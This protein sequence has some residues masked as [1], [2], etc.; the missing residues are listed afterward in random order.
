MAE[1][2][3]CERCRYFKPTQLEGSDPR[4]FGQC[5][6]YAPRAGLPQVRF[7]KESYQWIANIS[8]P[9]VRSGSFCGEF[10]SAG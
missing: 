7:G 6:R 1:A 3:V 10:E 9:V 8:W 5:H 2:M 4:A